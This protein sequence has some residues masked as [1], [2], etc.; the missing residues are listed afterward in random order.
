[1]EE[2]GPAAAESPLLVVALDAEPLLVEVRPN[3]AS[4]SSDNILV[5][6][7][8]NFDRTGG[9]NGETVTVRRRSFYDG[10][11]EHLVKPTEKM[12]GAEG[13]QAP[14]DADDTQAFAL[15]RSTRSPVY[16][17]AR[18]G[19]SG[20]GGHAPEGDTTAELR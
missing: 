19:T 4:N 2:I 9:G 10:V 13:G 12:I 14:P 20:V 16:P 3:R 11:R 1:M 7:V 17:V 6:G 5:H 8:M 18:L 15:V